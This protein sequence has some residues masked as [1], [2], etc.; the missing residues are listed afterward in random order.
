MRP[1][2]RHELELVGED[3]VL[4]QSG[5]LYWPGQR[6][7]IVA[8]LHLEKGSAMA[9]R[10]TMLP[11]YD[12]LMT[13]AKLEKLV[14]DFRPATVV[15]LGDGFHD[16]RGSKYLSAAVFDRLTE[17]MRRT[18]WCWIT[19][20]H[21][22][23]VPVELGG[24][25]CETLNVGKLTLRHEP[26]GSVGEVAGH[27]HPKARVSGRSRRVSRACFAADGERLLMPAFGWYAG[28]LNVL[29]DAVTCL[30]PSGFHAYLLGDRKIYPLPHR[31]L[32]GEPY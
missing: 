8:D 27:L 29:N 32:L 22:P 21:D 7:L 18:Q 5:I 23:R 14:G 11:P 25:V 9:R 4:D 3:L 20:N 28:G 16:G 17:L 15:S 10:G 31:Q 19:G 2:L 1:P 12:T 6:M 13:L 24:A 26:L 30:F